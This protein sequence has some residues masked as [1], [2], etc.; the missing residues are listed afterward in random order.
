M[1]ETL[2][3]LDL[4]FFDQNGQL[5]E[6]H[7]NL[8]PCEITVCKTYTNKKPAQYALELPAGTAKRLGIKK[9]TDFTIIKS[10]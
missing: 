4:I 2:I 8:Q 7:H 9:G 3:P 6:I 5:L 1:K 10:D